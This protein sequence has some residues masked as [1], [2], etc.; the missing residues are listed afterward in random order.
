MTIKEQIDEL[1]STYKKEFY[2]KTGLLLVA[3]PNA[4]MAKLPLYD[5]INYIAAYYSFDVDKITTRTST[6]AKVK[7]IV[8]II[9]LR[10]GYTDAEVYKALELDRTTLISI[11][12]R[13]SHK[14]STSK[15]YR[16]TLY[17]AMEYLRLNTGVILSDKIDWRSPD[18]FISTVFADEVPSIVDKD[19]TLPYANSKTNKIINYIKQYPEGVSYSNITS[20]FAEAF[21]GKSKV[22]DLIGYLKRTNQIVKINNI[23]TVNIASDI[24]KGSSERVQ[25][26]MEITNFIKSSAKGIRAA[27]VYN[28]FIPLFGGKTNV[29][30]ILRELRKTKKITLNNRL[31]K[32]SKLYENN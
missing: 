15:S 1:I 23:C 16:H 14:L 17:K 2:E 3:F 21:G 24:I 7:E 9:A 5:I 10:M 20:Y 22:R 27:E 6:A 26:A 29:S 4:A 19:N 12:G 32:V 13:V 31:Y 25:R 8:A 18:E 11:K 30:T 28:K